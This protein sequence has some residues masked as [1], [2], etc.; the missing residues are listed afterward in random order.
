MVN[1]CS[2][3]AYKRRTMNTTEF[4]E[5]LSQFIGTEQ[6]HRWSALYPHWLLTDGA[7][8]V[9]DEARAYWLMDLLAS[10]ENHPKT[11]HEYF[12]VW[13]LTKDEQEW[14]VTCEDG[15]NHKLVTQRIKYS[16]FPLP[17]FDLWAIF[18]GDYWVILLASEY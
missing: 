14:K 17:E 9:A 2:T 7:K 18:D 13:K 15:N 5:Q 12:Q 10:Y 3:F 4:K 8:F 11:R 1:P 16:D 6:W